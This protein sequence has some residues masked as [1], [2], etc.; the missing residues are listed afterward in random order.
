[1]YNVCFSS[2]SAH[3]ELLALIPSGILDDLEVSA[4][5]NLRFQVEKEEEGEKRM[6]RIHME[7]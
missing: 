2:N 3:L 7:S 1:M 6:G 5:C 4:G